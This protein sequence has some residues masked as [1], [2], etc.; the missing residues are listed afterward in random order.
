MLVPYKKIYF[1]DD[2]HSLIKSPYQDGGEM[3]IFRESNKN[4]IILSINYF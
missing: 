1:G 4:F 2:S 3:T